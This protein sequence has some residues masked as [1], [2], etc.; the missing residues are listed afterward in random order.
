[1]TN[2]NFSLIFG[3]SGQRY[4]CVSSSIEDDTGGYWNYGFHIEVE[5]NS[6]SQGLW[7][8]PN[9]LIKSALISGQVHLWIRSVSTGLPSP[10]VR[11]R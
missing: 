1:M 10:K 6:G 7:T 2:Y 11:G 8:A 3:V 4:S 5:V 9:W